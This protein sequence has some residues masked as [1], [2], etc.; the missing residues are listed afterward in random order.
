M[1]VFSSELMMKSLLLRGL[2]SQK[3]AYRSRTRPA[4]SAKRGSRGKIQYSYRHGLIASASRMRQTVL[5]LMARPRAVEARAARSVV[6]NRLKG[7]WVWLTASQAM[8]LTTAW[9][10][11]EKI[12][13][14]P[15]SCLIGQ[16]EIALSPTPPPEAY[17]VGVQL[18]GGPCRDV[19]HGR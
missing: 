4:F 17:G 18:H 3:P 6:D 9:S 15:A 13:L 5:E 16:G 1:L 2:F 11:G 14:S 10:R 19:G 7:S 12:G 8:A